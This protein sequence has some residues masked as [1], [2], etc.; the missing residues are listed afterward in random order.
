MIRQIH[1]FTYKR[2]CISLKINN[3]KCYDSCPLFSLNKIKEMLESLLQKASH[4]TQCNKCLPLL[5]YLSRAQR[6]FLE[7]ARVCCFGLYHIASFCNG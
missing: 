1:L 4:L 6:R 7:V 5:V 3:H 2:A